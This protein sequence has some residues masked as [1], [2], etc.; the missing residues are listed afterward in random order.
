LSPDSRS[1]RSLEPH[2]FPI[3]FAFPPLHPLY[4]CDTDSEPDSVHLA[5][6]KKSLL[7][8]NKRQMQ[9]ETD[10]LDSSSDQASM[11]PFSSGLATRSGRQHP[12]PE[13]FS[14]PHID[15]VAVSDDS[16]NSPK[17]MDVD[18]GMQ[19]IALGSLLASPPYIPQLDNDV[20]GPVPQVHMIGSDSESDG[21]I[22]TDDSGAPPAVN[23]RVIADFDDNSPSYIPNAVMMSDLDSEEEQN[24]IQEQGSLAFG[25]DPVTGEYTAASFEHFQ[26]EWL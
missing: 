21:D 23:F 24:V 11:P 20:F 22:Y 2:E 6:S 17:Q 1:I 9:Q 18:D 15:V 13:L 8:R 25:R 10:L 4:A 7:M 5:F 14:R 16:S 26:E 3:A 19:P 12:L